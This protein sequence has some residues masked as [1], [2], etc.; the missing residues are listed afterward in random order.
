MPRVAG[1]GAPCLRAER[2]KSPSDATVL[3]RLVG[4]VRAEIDNVGQKSVI[5]RDRVEIGSGSGFVISPDGHVLTNEHVVSN[6]E[7][8]IN[9]PNRKVVIRVNVSKIEVCF[10]PESAAARGG[11]TPCAEA[12]I[13]AADPDLDLA[14]LYVGSSNQPYLALGDSDVVTPGSRCRRSAFRSAGRSTSAAT[15][16]I[17]SC[18]RSRRRS[19]RSRR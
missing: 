6:S 13:A 5:T 19:G 18:R 2:A 8:T 3:V 16:W 1:R 14:V 12:T 17:R 4:S 10:P 11:T 9:E 15:R 7:I